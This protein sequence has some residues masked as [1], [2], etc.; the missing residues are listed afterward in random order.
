MKRCPRCQTNYTDEVR[1]CPADGTPTEQVAPISLAALAVAATDIP[2]GSPTIR[3]MTAVGPVTAG[4]DIPEVSDGPSTIPEST[5]LMADQPRITPTGGLGAGSRTPSAPEHSPPMPADPDTLRGAPSA[6]AQRSPGPQGPST[7]NSAPDVPADPT[8]PQGPST[9]TGSP[10]VRAPAD[11]L[12][13]ISRP[14]DPTGPQGPSTIR[15]SASPEVRAPAHNQTMLGATSPLP[16]ATS[17]G[18]PAPRT[19]SPTP[20][21]SSNQT[22]IGGTSPLPIATG[23]GAPAPRT[24]SPTAAPPASDQTMFGAPSFAPNQTPNQTSPPNFNQTMIGAPS[25]S[26]LAGPPGAV[27]AG[28]GILSS[29]TTVPGA[30]LPP[31]T[32]ALA[33]TF[34]GTTSEPPRPPVG[35]PLTPSQLAAT[36]PQGNTFMGAAS[37]V[38]RAPASP[39]PPPPLPT[40]AH[41]PKPGAITAGWDIP[42]LSGGGPTTVPDA[43][44]PPIDIAALRGSAEPNLAITPL[45]STFTGAPPGPPRAPATAAHTP[46]PGPGPVSLGWD[47]P[48]KPAD[49]SF[50]GLAASPIAA[51]AAAQPTLSRSSA[52]ATLPGFAPPAEIVLAIQEQ[53]AKTAVTQAPQPMSPPEVS[54][55]AYE[56]SAPAEPR[57][58]NP[59]QATMPAMSPLPVQPVVVLMASQASVTSPTS[60]APLPSVSMPITIPKLPAP[61]TPPI[62]LPGSSSTS[63]PPTASLLEAPSYPATSTSPAGPHVK[64][65]RSGTE[66]PVGNRM[67]WIVLIVI[68]LA[69]VAAAVTFVVTR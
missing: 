36:T 8:G 35:S 17:F 22:M 15:G 55:E 67:L 63:R 4:W 13:M 40:E 44:V 39:T 32:S 9:I 69:I 62:E 29:P 48:D 45:L 38:A 68:A 58:T 59:M 7:T 65:E 30:P 64:R 24:P 16:I 33:N 11:D 61:S 42:E 53:R 18:A 60:H 46:R 37:P 57:T 14:L 54:H 56:R 28:W 47:I 12:A 3:D 27:T 23:F 43:P 6:I 25:S 34:M 50:T 10:D 26:P 66:R 21:S 52:S 31:I 41:L 5:G 2:E 51:L 1:W 49:A 19:S 20:A